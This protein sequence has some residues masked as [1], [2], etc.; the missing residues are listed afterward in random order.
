[1]EKR[2]RVAFIGNSHMAYWPLE[3]FF[4]QWE[5]INYGLP[6]EGLDYVASFSRDVSDCKVVIQFGTNDLYR[7]NYDNMQAYA[8]DYVEAVKAIHAKEKYLFCIFP[9]NDYR[10][11]VSVNRLIAS[12]NA[13]IKSRLKDTDIVYLDVFSRLLSDN[14]C[15]NPDY[16]VDDLH[17]N[18]SG[19]RIL[20]ECLMQHVA[21]VDSKDL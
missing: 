3:V 11:S 18:G 12:L 4:P 15:L 9:R 14:G 13:E 21:L 5:C 7:L 19:Y 6:G 1:M 10:G 16:T 2:M 8:Q 17:L 20:A